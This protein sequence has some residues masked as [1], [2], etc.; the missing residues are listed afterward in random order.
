MT[1]VCS[2]GPY[3][4]CQGFLNR[5]TTGPK[6]SLVIQPLK[7]KCG[8]FDLKLRPGRELRGSVS[9]RLC[10]SQYRPVHRAKTESSVFDCAVSKSVSRDAVCGANVFLA[11][12][13]HKDSAT[14]VNKTSQAP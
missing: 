7:P 6:T 12:R 5:V 2:V 9:Q 1:D 14:N 11:L 8:R 3:I 10:Y 4:S 13:K